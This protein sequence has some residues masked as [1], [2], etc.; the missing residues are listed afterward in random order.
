MSP[1][2]DEPAWLDA[3][4]SV[5]CDELSRMSGMS[6]AELE[7]LVDYGALVP[8]PGQDEERFSADCVIR[9]RDAARLRGDFDL[10]LFTVSLLLGYMERIEHLERRLRALEAQM[11]AHLA[12]RRDGPA[13]WHEPHA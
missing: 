6:V 8:L 2:L 10:D 12:G 7:E 5:R 13:P 11:P 3:R 9:L 1:H 4:R